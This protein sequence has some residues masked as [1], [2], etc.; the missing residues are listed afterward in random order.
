M[1]YE[2]LLTL[3]LNAVKEYFDLYSGSVYFGS[4]FF[5]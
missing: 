4:V 2:S 3:I 5:I 1:S